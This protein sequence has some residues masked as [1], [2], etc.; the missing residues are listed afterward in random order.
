MNSNK[1]GF[2]N[3][4][5][6]QTVFTGVVDGLLKTG[7]GDGILRADVNVAFGS[8]DGVAADGHGFH[9]AVGVAFKDGTVHERAGVAL[10]RVADHVLLIGFILRSEEPLLAGR[11]TGAA[12]AAQTGIG[13]DLDDLFGG[14]FG[15]HLAQRLIAVHGDILVDAFGVDD[16]AVAQRDALLL[17]VEDGVVQRHVGLVDLI[18]EVIRHVV[19]DKA[20]HHTALE[21]VFFHDLLDV[22]LFHAGIERSVGIDDDH[23]TEGAEAEAAGS[24][25]FDFARQTVFLDLRFK[26]GNQLGAAG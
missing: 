15:E 18:L 6:Q 3:V 2:K 12:A 9:D 22:A 7:H 11:E 13:D 23:G 16:A 24:D 14:H 8:A 10:I 20:F 25:N 1:A 26:L 17:G 19:V 5:A 4:L 21:K